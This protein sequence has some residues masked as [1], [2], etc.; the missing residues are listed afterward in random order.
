MMQL[1]GAITHTT[2]HDLCTPCMHS[3][4]AQAFI[5]LNA[6]ERVEGCDGVTVWRC[7]GCPLASINRIVEKGLR[8]FKNLEV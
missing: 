1:A 5:L 2:I 4:R 8:S 6:F 3:S 7:C